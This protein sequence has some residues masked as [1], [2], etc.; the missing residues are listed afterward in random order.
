MGHKRKR[1]QD[2]SIVELERA[3]RSAPEGVADSYARALIE[4]GNQRERSGQA[5]AALYDYRAASVIAASR[6]VQEQSIVC[7]RR[8]A[9]GHAAGEAARPS[10]WHALGRLFGFGRG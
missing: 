9:A 1:D 8:L 2:T 6:A 10:F 7:T 3:Y 4:R 5:E